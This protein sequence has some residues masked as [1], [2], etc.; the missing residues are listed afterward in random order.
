MTDTSDSRQR[1]RDLVTAYDRSL[2]QQ[3]VERGSSL[4]CRDEELWTRVEALLRD[5]DAQET[6][7]LGLDPLAV[8]EESLKAAAASVKVTAAAKVTAAPRGGKVKARGGGGLQGLAKAFE[9]L[10]QAAL[11]LYLG[12]WR[13]EYKVVKMYSGMFTHHIRPVLSMP[14]AEKLFGLLGYEPGA[15]RREQLFLQAL[16][17]GPASLDDLLRLSCAFYLARCECR[18]MQ[19][20][21]GKHVGEAQWELSVVRE[22][23][24]GNSLQVAL[25]NAK[26][27]LKVKQPPTEPFDVDMDLY[28]DEHVNGGRVAAGARADK[29]W[30]TQRS[31]SPPAVKTHSDGLTSLSSSSCAS[32]PGREN[33]CISTLS[34][35]LAKTS[36]PEAA[37]GESKGRGRRPGEGSRFDDADSGSRSVRLRSEATGLCESEADR[38]C[39][40]LDLAQLYLKH[41][42]DC[43][44]LHGFTCASLQNC[45]LVHSVVTFYDLTEGGSESGVVSLQSEKSLRAS[46]ANASPTLAAG[47]SSAAMSSLVL[48]DDND[49]GPTIPS[50]HP[51]TYHDCCDLARL[52]PRVLCRSCGV[53]H[54]SSCRDADY[55]HVHHTVRPLGVCVCGKACAR[56]PLVLCRY[57]GNEYCRDCWYRNP[58]VCVCGQTFDQS[59]SV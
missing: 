4:A 50:L 17:I 9:V 45:L 35:Q 56:K 41:C 51:F 8:M 43:N 30:P 22:R 19:A 46:D 34:C 59:S 5:G 53:F 24:R 12:P 55:C 36:P 16:K 39:S 14:Q 31:L 27:T 47:C 44:T 26:K 3:I 32:P 18:L 2:E 25:D 28:T 42:V 52:D 6:H 20:A 58:V 33:V 48:R 38:F 49:P 10:E 11:N 54:S 7:C 40:C 15:A 1:A 23:Q 13:G 21:L 57:C 37:V 29:P